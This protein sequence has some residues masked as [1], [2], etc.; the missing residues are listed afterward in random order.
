M[1]KNYSVTSLNPRNI[2]N[3][4][5]ICLISTLLGA[6][7]SILPECGV[8]SSPPLSD[9]NGRW[10]LA[11]WNR[12]PDS[13]GRVRLR[14]LPLDKNNPATLVFD[15]SN[16]RLSG[17]SGCNSFTTTVSEHPKGIIPG[18]LAGTRKMCVE[19]AKSEFETDFMYQLSDYRSLKMENNELLL[20][21]RDGDILLFIR[22]K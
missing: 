2:R 18:Q 17:F 8:C 20:V 11:K 19:L 3:L 21:G 10:E 16:H 13:Q 5:L 12:A 1:T 6:C 14:T 7:T 9:L 4:F 22:K 15:L